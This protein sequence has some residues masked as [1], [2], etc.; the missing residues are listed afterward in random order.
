[1]NEQDVT[2]KNATAYLLYGI[3]IDCDKLGEKKKTML[4]DGIP[5]VSVIF[6]PGDRYCVLGIVL[7]RID[8]GKDDNVRSLNTVEI[9]MQQ[10]IGKA[11]HSVGIASLKS[12]PYRMWMVVDY[13]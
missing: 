9:G 11:V 6:E 13:E 3:Q 5:G 2:I 12:Q 1:M 4:L 8:L 10:K 7:C